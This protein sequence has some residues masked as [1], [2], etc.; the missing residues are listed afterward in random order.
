MFIT[1]TAMFVAYINVNQGTVD[2]IFSRI[3]LTFNFDMLNRIANL[4]QFIVNI[5]LKD[6]TIG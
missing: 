6:V 4:L 1:G 5:H 2:K 3:I